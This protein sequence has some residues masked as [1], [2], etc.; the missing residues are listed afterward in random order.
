M[1][2]FTRLK[3]VA[4]HVTFAKQDRLMAKAQK[5]KN[6]GFSREKAGVEFSGGLTDAELDSVYK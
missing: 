1:S 3:H 4:A 6:K 2:F 5:F